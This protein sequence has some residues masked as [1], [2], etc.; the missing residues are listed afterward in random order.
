M[1]RILQ[2]LCTLILVCGLA[3]FGVANAQTP[4]QKGYA[5]AQKAD[6]LGSNFRD[7]TAD[8]K[9]V[10]R[11]GGGEAVRQFSFKSQKLR[12]GSQ[13]I[14]VFSW[15]GDI[16]DTGLLTVSAGGRSD[17]QWIF[18]P[19]ARRVKR[20]SSSSRSG[21]FV[22]SEFS[23]EDMTDQG[24]DDFTYRWVRD[25]GCCNIVER[26]PKGAS[27]YA[28][29]VVWFNKG[30]GLVDRV[31]FHP[32]RGNAQ[33]VLDISGYRQYGSVWRPSQMVMSNLLTSR[34]TILS[35]SNYRFNAGLSANDFTTRALERGL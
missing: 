28:K 30:S 25:E 34:S 18:L 22:G 1:Y 16:R 21:S 8:G 15:P 29:Q 27:S 26:Y 10:L 4:E 12:G 32:K 20:I 17:D 7:F 13:S 35:W 2:G 11:T 23:Y 6:A 9:M 19:A 33:K 5:I 24:L 3:P 31:E 14:L